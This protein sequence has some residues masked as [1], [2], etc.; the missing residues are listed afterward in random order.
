MIYDQRQREKQI[1]R[2]N[3]EKRLASGEIDRNDL[4]RENGLFFG[5]KVLVRLDLAE[6]LS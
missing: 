2:E 3:D 6:S 5:R 4:R 1:S